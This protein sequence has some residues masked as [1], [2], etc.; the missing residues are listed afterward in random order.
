MMALMLFLLVAKDGCQGETVGANG[1]VFHEREAGGCTRRVTV[2]G[3]GDCYYSLKRLISGIGITNMDAVGTFTSGDGEIVKFRDANSDG[4]FLLE[5]V[6]RVGV[7]V[8]KPSHVLHVHGERRYTKALGHVSL[9]QRLQREVTQIDTD[10]ALTAI[11][12]ID[13]V[14]FKF[15]DAYGTTVGLKGH[16]LRGVSSQQVLQ[17]IPESVSTLEGQESFGSVGGADGMVE[18]D[19][20][21]LVDH[22]RL[23]YDAIAAIQALATKHDALRA[24]HESLL[25]E[26]K[27]LR[28]EIAARDT[29][30]K[31]D[32]DNIRA[33][34]ASES[35]IRA[36]DVAT[37]QAALDSEE[38]ART[39]D[40]EKLTKQLA[41]VSEVFTSY[42][43]QAWT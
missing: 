12:G 10:A 40:V 35:S 43:E 28:A 30:D 20:M 4:E 26:V 24:D 3:E 21:K 37:L 36:K 15:H 19:S 42:G 6:D 13:I 11:R 22:S 29:T 8:R 25:S 17:V 38:T 39:V 5:P 41:Y 33:V 16:S 27:Q 14:D 23:F 7:R 18:V 1:G 32:R 2:N 34:L 9:D 31:D